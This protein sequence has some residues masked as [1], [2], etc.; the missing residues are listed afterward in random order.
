MWICFERVSCLF[1]F[2]LFVYLHHGSHPIICL[3]LH[4]CTY[5]HV[6]SQCFFQSTIAQ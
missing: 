4:F 5:K 3:R 1:C 2:V 6:V